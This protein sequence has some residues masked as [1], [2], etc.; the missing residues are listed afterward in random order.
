MIQDLNLCPFIFN[1]RK[2][3]EYFK[4]P[5]DVKEEK[6]GQKSSEW[7]EPFYTRMAEIGQSMQN[8]LE[9]E[10]RM[11]EDIIK[12]EKKDHNGRNHNLRAS[13]WSVLA[14]DWIHSGQ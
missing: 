8:R 7:A 2:K 4:K 9:L 6:S 10:K 11:E 13:S 14:T 1:G 5:K 12:K 3:K